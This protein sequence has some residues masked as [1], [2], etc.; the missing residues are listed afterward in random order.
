MIAIATNG[1]EWPAGLIDSECLCWAWLLQHFHPLMLRRIG[2]IAS[3]LGSCVVMGCG[4]LASTSAS[5]IERESDAAGSVAADSSGAMGSS[6]TVS[7]SG[8]T[9][10]SGTASVTTGSSGAY[11]GGLP[12]SADGQDAGVVQGRAPGCPNT[13][14]LQGS[15]CL[16]PGAAC[17]YPGDAG[18]GLCT[19]YATCGTA[20]NATTSTWFLSQDAVCG[21]PN[22]PV[23]PATFAT[24]APGAPCPGDPSLF[25]VYTEGACGCVPCQADARS[26]MWA[27]RN[28]GPDQAGCPQDPPLIGDAC[29]SGQGCS[30][31]S[32]CVFSVGP[33]V[34]CQNG[35]WEGAG[36]GGSCVI[37]TCGSN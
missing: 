16:P 34:T 33:S 18:H 36:G 23:C 11:N 7:S 6:G 22:A 2:Q 9:G 37:Q 17:D 13:L 20:E 21:K 10:S 28:W 14:P 3:A 32:P 5:E 25:C 31:G 1:T 29:T 35:Y 30:Y 15:P 4:G 19:T 24:L 12:T 8:A 27:C 26:N